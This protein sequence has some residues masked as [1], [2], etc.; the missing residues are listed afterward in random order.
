MSTIII[1]ILIFMVLTV[2]YKGIFLLY[3]PSSQVFSTTKSLL[4]FV[5]PRARDPV[6]YSVFRYF[7]LVNY[8]LFIMCFM[9]NGRLK[10]IHLVYFTRNR[11]VRNPG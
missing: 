4:K 2:N 8:A 7:C 11:L 10:L 5:L 3:L 9:R 1:S 6:Y